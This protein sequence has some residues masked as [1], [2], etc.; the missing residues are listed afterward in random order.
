MT[1]DD[2]VA[3]IGS[4]NMDMRSFSL[5]Y[6]NSLFIL[7]GPLITDLCGLAAAYLSVSRELTLTEWNQRPWSRRYIDNVLKLTSAL[8]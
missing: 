2:E 4:S 3:I 6:E 1:I 7:D 8:Q 5:N